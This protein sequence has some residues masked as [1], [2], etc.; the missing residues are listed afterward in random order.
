MRGG[1]VE[2][3]DGRVFEKRSGDGDAL[4]LASGELCAAISDYRF[5]A[6]GKRF[7]EFAREGRFGGFADARGV[8]VVFAVGDVFRYRVVEEKCLLRDEADF[9]SQRC[10]REIADIGAVDAHRA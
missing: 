2:D 7:D 4:A 3:Q 5:V 1:F 6:V 10:E 9:V 8:N